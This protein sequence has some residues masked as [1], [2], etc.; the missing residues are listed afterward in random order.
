MIIM[1]KILYYD[2][3]VSIIINFVGGIYFIYL[4]IKENRKNARRLEISIKLMEKQ[5]FL[6]NV[7]CE[8]E[9]NKFTAFI[10]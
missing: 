9:K 10:E 1:E 5:K 7:A 8:I 2:T 4:V 6:D 3:A